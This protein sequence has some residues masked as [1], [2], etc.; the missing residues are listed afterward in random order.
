MAMVERAIGLGQT[1]RAMVTLG[2]WLGPWADMRG[3]PRAVIRR[4]LS[5]A[6]AR[7]LASFDAWL[8]RP[9]HVP[10]RGAYAIAPGMHFDGPADPRMDRLC[11]VLAQAG[12]LVVAPFVPDFL[13]LRNAPGAVDD[14]ER[15]LDVLTALPEYPASARPRLFS[16]SFGSRL[17][18]RVAA[19]KRYARRLGHVVV[20]GGYLDWREVVRFCLH[21]GENGKPR[22]PLNRPVVFINLLEPMLETLGLPG[23]AGP[24]LRD[25]WLQ[26]T[27]ATWSRQG[28]E[29]VSDYH[30]VAERLARAL[31]PDGVRELFLMGCGLRPGG[32]ELCARVLQQQR[33]EHLEIQPHLSRIECPVHVVHGADDDVIPVS[34]AH[35]LAGALPAH[36]GHLYITGL[37]GHTA[38]QGLW[39]NVPVLGREASTLLR[40]LHVLAAS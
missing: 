29:R 5:V 36:A 18:L 15:T 31:E 39:R 38:S 14:F 25:A 4:T 30:P 10:V 12:F 34:E 40:L 17:A 35:A 24:L 26:F 21:E 7:S 13:E 9:L 28:R 3:A 1:A 23:E 32:P 22:D 19:S 8:Y 2:R 11:R 20:F 16:I 33:P 27:R 37:Y 6:G